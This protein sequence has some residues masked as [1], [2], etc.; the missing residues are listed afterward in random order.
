MLL[1]WHITLIMFNS[2]LC[3]N[4]RMEYLF[5]NSRHIYKRNVYIYCYKTNLGSEDLLLAVLY[6]T[7]WITDVNIRAPSAPAQD[8][9]TQPGNALASAGCCQQQSGCSWSAAHWTHTHEGCGPKRKNEEETKSKKDRENN[10]GCHMRRKRE[11]WQRGW[12]WIFLIYGSGKKVSRS[13]L[14][15]YQS[16]DGCGF[17]CAW[18][19]N[20]QCVVFG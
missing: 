11:R 17:A 9:E 12:I 1:F 10:G 18:H 3:F 20:N 8:A 6:F 19:A 2:G 16:A 13:Q 4:K 14:G 15:L 5:L 7:H